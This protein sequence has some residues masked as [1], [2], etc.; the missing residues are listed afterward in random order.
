VHPPEPNPGAAPTFLCSKTVAG[1]LTW[2]CQ[3]QKNVTQETANEH[4][5]FGMKLGSF[6]FYVRD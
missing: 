4:Q 3:A 2:S 6:L 5:W 1:H